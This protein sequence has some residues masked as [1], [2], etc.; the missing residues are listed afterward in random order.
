M[1]MTSLA[2]TCGDFLDFYLLNQAVSFVSTC[3]SKTQY[4]QGF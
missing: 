4:F 2:M 1:N 3:L